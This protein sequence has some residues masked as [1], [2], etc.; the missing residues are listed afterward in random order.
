[1]EEIKVRLRDLPFL[2]RVIGEDGASKLYQLLPGHPGKTL[3][4]AVLVGRL[5]TELAREADGEK[6]LVLCRAA[7]TLGSDAEAGPRSVATQVA[8]QLA[9]RELT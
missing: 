6:D 9:A 8:G 2:V 5:A 3:A 7:M 1:M 4:A